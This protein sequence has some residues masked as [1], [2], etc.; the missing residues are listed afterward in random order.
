M[1]LASC[2]GIGTAL[3]CQFLTG[4][5]KT[6]NII[7]YNY[8][9]KVY[10]N[11]VSKKYLSLQNKTKTMFTIVEVQV[12]KINLF[13]SKFG[14]EESGG[15]KP[16]NC[17]VSMEVD[18]DTSLNDGNAI[19]VVGGCNENSAKVRTKREFLRDNLFVNFSLDKY[20]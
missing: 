1:T 11:K 10:I 12:K 2:A 5:E 4:A 3:K 9:E 13:P 16:K 19:S 18:G 17:G 14:N 8:A 20:N 7:I 6:V 15:S